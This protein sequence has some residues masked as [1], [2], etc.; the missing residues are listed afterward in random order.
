MPELVPPTNNRPHVHET[1]DLSSQPSSGSNRQPRE[2]CKKCNQLIVEG[3]AYE[4]GDDRWHIHCFNC[5]KCNTSLGCNSNFLVLGNGNL[6]CSNCSYNCKQCGRKIDDLAI[7]TGDQAYC[8]NCFKCRSCKNKIED[9]RYARTSK[10]LF[11]M[12]CHQKLMAK[13]KKY[14]AKKKHLA[15]LQEKR[16][17]LEREKDQRE[18]QILEDHKRS[19]NSSRNSLIQSYMNNQSN[20]SGESLLYQQNNRSVT[21]VTSSKNKSL[22][23]PPTATS[24][25]RPTPYTANSYQSKDSI[26]GKNKTDSSLGSLSTSQTLSEHT[27]KGNSTLHNSTGLHNPPIFQSDNDFS[28]EEVQ[29]SSDSDT[30][31]DEKKSNGTSLRNKNSNRSSKVLPFVN[32]YSTPPLSSDQLSTDEISADTG[33][34]TVYLD[35]IDTPPESKADPLSGNQLKP[36]LDVSPGG[37]PEQKSK[38]FLILSPNQFHDNEFHNTRSPMIDSP[39][40]II[41]QNSNQN[42]KAV[43]L[44]VEDKPRSG[45]PSPFAKV[46]RQARVVETNDEILTDGVDDD[47]AIG[48]PRQEKPSRAGTSKSVSSPPPR[49]PLPSTPSRGDDASKKFS[50]VETPKGLGLEGVDYDNHEDQRSYIKLQQD[51]RQH[52]ISEKTS[53]SSIM[54]TPKR[55]VGNFSPAVTNLEPKNSDWSNDQQHKH[56]QKNQNVSRTASIIK[57]LKHK[58]STSGNQ[59]KL[60]ALFTT[61]NREDHRNGHTRQTSDGSLFS[62]IAN[63]YISP[64]ITNSGLGGR[65][66][67]RLTSDSTVLLSDE[68]HYNNV[69]MKSEIEQLSSSKALLDQDVKKLRD[70]KHKLNEQLKMIQSKISSESIRYDNLV[71][72]IAELQAQKTKI[73]NENKELIEQQKNRQASGATGKLS[74]SFSN[75]SDPD[76][77]TLGKSVN[78]HLSPYKNSSD[79]TLVVSRDNYEYL[80]HL[81]PDRHQAQYQ[82]QQQ[83]QYQQQYHQHQLQQSTEDEQTHKATRLKFWRRPKVGTT[84]AIPSNEYNNNSNAPNNGGGRIPNSFSTQALRIP[85]QN[86]GNSFNSSGANNNN[87]QNKFSKSKSSNILDSLLSG[88][89][90]QVPLFDST[91]QQRADYE[92]N[93][94]PIIVTR[95]IA[96]VEKRGLDFEGIYRISGGNSA[97]VSIE[98]AFASLSNDPDEKQLSRVEETLDVDIH[99]VTSA[100]KRY[101]R[102]LPDPVIPFVLYEDFINVSTKASHSK[103]VR[104]A[105]LQKIVGKLPPANR[106]TL[107]LIV[108]HLHL[109]NSLQNVNKM[110]YKNLSVVFA[111]T[112]AKDK[113][114]DNEMADMGF[115]NDSTELLLTESHRIF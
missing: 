35:I 68:D 54:S 74:K 56:L 8:S 31:G 80:D 32:Q 76:A 46:N 30:N 71:A 95:C 21:S 90:N 50:F 17:Q 66:H 101:L 4:L 63:A 26:S 99:A 25:T 28:I 67:I 84:Q 93:Q 23:L 1:L 75:D 87:H 5:S 7:L 15:L 79:S 20:Q 89:S 53:P 106:E 110:G 45:C 86:S 29:N 6:I 111:P 43:N 82:Q 12:D 85:A 65:S 36:A 41:S 44:S 102:K 24:P 59:N 42:T 34:K 73:T 9:L 13:K 39:G 69:A 58:R 3:H 52:D 113:S 49:V 88:D 96:E 91:L 16:L 57:N 38:N 64:P 100:L 47:L 83:Q 18:M 77:S 98:N 104:I 70:E 61:S 14:D 97:I 94:V 19:V 92:K 22:P 78:T 107:R 10:G 51:Q 60:A 48:T 11:C 27:N 112:L 114:G 2:L 55:V 72:E 40:T 62:S 81:S 105:E 109:V 103:E 37:N 115:R 108:N 33:E